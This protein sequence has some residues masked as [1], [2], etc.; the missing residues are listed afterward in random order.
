M[1]ARARMAVFALMLFACDASVYSA[2][3]GGA[4]A[5]RDAERRPD[6]G[7]L[8]ETGAAQEAGSACNSGWVEGRVADN[9]APEADKLDWSNPGLARNLDGAYASVA[10]MVPGKD[11]HS[12]YVEDFGLTVPANVVISGIEAEITRKSSFAKG[13]RDLA[14][15]LYTDEFSRANRANSAVVWGTE[16]TTATYGAANDLWGSVWSPA[17]IN[18]KGF[19][20]VLAVTFTADLAAGIDMPSVDRMRVRVSW[21]CP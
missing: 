9:F 14:V 16:L 6:G 3:I 7:Q 4:D 18:D 1:P 13:I 11:S 2:N 8:S 20:L 19:S 10:S 12:M 15:Q 17:R 21:I 5:A